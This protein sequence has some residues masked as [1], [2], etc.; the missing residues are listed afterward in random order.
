[1]VERKIVE[2]YYYSVGGEDYQLRDDRDLQRA[3]NLL[4][5]PHEM[6]KI[7]TGEPDA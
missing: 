6:R 5:T 3:I 4:N 1:M 2:R 7:L